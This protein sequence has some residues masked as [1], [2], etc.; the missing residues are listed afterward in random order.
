ML[1]SRC[2]GTKDFTQDDKV[3]GE[4]PALSLVLQVGFDPFFDA[5]AALVF[6]V[7]ADAKGLVGLAPA[8]LGPHPDAR[9]SQQR[10]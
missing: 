8:H 1:S 9:Q 5:L 3:A 2:R 7:E 6:V 4:E 10:E